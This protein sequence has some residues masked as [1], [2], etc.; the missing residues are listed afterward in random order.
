LFREQ[1]SPLRVSRL[2]QTRRDLA[3]FWI[4]VRRQFRHGQIRTVLRID[5]IALNALREIRLAARFLAALMTGE[6]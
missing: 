5:R 1:A 6:S 3:R 4:A 2:R